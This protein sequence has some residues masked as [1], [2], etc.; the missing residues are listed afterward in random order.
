M[1]APRCRRRGA[2]AAIDQTSDVLVKLREAV[3]DAQSD[4]ASAS[5]YNTQI[6]SLLS[7]I[8][9][10]ESDATVNGVNPLAGAVV[11]DVTTTQ[12]VVPRNLTGGNITIGEKSLSQMNASVPAL[13]LDNF[14]ATSG[15]LNISFSSLSVENIGTAA[16]PTQVQVQTANYGT[17][18]TAQYP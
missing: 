13:G 9:R 6:Q 3:I 11:D 15:G 14:T 4:D 18:E 2:G 7:G 8:G 17:G 12:I 1:R 5:A 16:P 10:N